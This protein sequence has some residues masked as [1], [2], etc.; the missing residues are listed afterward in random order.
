[1]A[2][3][4]ELKNKR[5]DILLN[6]NHEE[7]I[8]YYDSLAKEELN[9]LDN[10]SFKEG[11]K[12]GNYNKI[13]EI[14]KIIRESNRILKNKYPLI[15]PLIYVSKFVELFSK[16]HEA[17]TEGRT[18]IIYIAFIHMAYTYKTLHKTLFKLKELLTLFYMLYYSKNENIANDI[19]ETF[20][21]LIEETVEELEETISILQ[22]VKKLNYDPKTKVNEIY[23]AEIKTIEKN[24]FKLQD[25]IKY[26]LDYYEAL[27]EEPFK[28]ANEYLTISYINL[29]F[30]TDVSNIEA[31]EESL[32]TD[33]E[34]EVLKAI[35]EAVK[36]NTPSYDFKKFKLIKANPEGVVN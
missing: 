31:F 5:K 7:L 33:K 16:Y 29:I 3:I 27:K 21:I 36:Y 9:N 15:E 23:T 13:N 6:M 22:K 30:E 14:E 8:S 28:E 1:M 35:K 25:S 26:Y 2:N 20:N 4:N 24:I 18:Y 32:E 12:Q 19:E 17:I 11:F 10:I 34:K